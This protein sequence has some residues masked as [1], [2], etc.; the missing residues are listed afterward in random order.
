MSDPIEPIE[1]AEGDS[2]QEPAAQPSA[3]VDAGVEAVL[4]RLGK[5]LDER[6]SGFQSLVDRKIGGLNSQ[7]SELKAQYLT[8]EERAAQEQESEKKE[9]ESLRM[10]NQLFRLRQD[11]PD[12]VD[13]IIGA[14]G[15]QSLEDQ[16][17]FI[18][19]KMGKKAI[20]QVEA[21]VE[22]DAST[23]GE[24]DQ[25]NPG[26]K[27]KMGAAT[28]AFTEIDSEEAADAILNSQPKGALAALRRI[29]R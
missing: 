18:E 29:G 28:A 7:L 3:N 11:H 26:R 15:T 19:S 13:L 5:T 23:G 4:D 16:I 8:P 2:A 22:A 6:F 14:M 21:A 20:A 9:I 12:A 25:N 27:P 24:V 1:Q 10:E 17:A